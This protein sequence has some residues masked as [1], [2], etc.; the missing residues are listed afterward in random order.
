VV[1]F[2]IFLFLVFRAGLCG[3]GKIKH[4]KFRA[5]TFVKHYFRVFWQL[6]PL[7]LMILARKKYGWPLWT[8]NCI[9]YFWSG[10]RAGLSAPP[11]VGDFKFF[12]LA[13][14]QAFMD[15]RQKW[16][17]HLTGLDM[18]FLAILLGYSTSSTFVKHYFGVFVK[19]HPLKLIIL[20][21]KKYGWHR[22]MI[23]QLPI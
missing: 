5:G 14:G 16:Y 1:F 3:L 23:L 4:C 15:L 22:T 17:N 20:A 9:Q 2:F 8:W 13:L 11:F 21:R 10:F 12:D 7:K 6:H 19:I 18:I